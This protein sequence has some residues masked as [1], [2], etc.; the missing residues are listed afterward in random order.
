MKQE[1]AADAMPTGKTIVPRVDGRAGPETVSHLGNKIGAADLPAS[2]ITERRKRR[3][4]PHSVTIRSAPRN[5]RQEQ[6]SSNVL[7]VNAGKHV[8]NKDV[9]ISTNRL[10]DMA[11]QRGEVDTKVVLSAC[12]RGSALMWYSIESTN[13]QQ[14]FW[15]EL[16][17][18]K[19]GPAC[20]FLGNVSCASGFVRGV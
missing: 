17:S 1:E 5:Q 10:E 14:Q 6:G 7:I 4:V 16:E 8:F 15:T 3:I 19:Y 2:V 20:C 11:A 9:Y 12:F 13:L 18:C